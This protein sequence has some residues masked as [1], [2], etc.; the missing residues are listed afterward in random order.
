MRVLLDQTLCAAHGDCVVAAPKIFDLD[1][2]DDFARV[3]DENPPEDS[4]A[5]VE[6]AVRVCPVGAITLQE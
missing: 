2:D 3:L 6:L 4:R 1:D 5:E